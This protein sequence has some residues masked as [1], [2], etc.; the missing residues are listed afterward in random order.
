MIG[1]M[2]LATA[3]ATRYRDAQS[4]RRAQQRPKLTRKLHPKLT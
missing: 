1:E 3:R 4:A 2:D